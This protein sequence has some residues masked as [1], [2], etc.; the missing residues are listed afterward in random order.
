MTLNE[1][2]ESKW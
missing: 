2:S 1:V